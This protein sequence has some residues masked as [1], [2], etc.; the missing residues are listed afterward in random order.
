MWK[1]DEEMLTD[2]VK[3]AMDDTLAVIEEKIKKLH[4]E[5]MVAIRVEDTQPSTWHNLKCQLVD[6]DSRILRVANICDNLHSISLKIKTINEYLLPG[7]AIP[8]NA[9]DD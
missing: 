5:I 1:G 8:G 2:E 9:S 6:I 3:N 7:N 4:E